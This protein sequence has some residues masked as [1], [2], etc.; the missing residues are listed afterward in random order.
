MAKKI[1][2]TIK[3]IIGWLLL[4]LFVM[5]LAAGVFVYLKAPAYV[6]EN[7]SE[8]VNKKSNGVYNLQFDNIGLS[9]RKWG[10]TV[11]NIKLQP[12]DSLIHL[13]DPTQTKKIY[14]SFSSSEINIRNIGLIKLLF[15][16]ELKI[17]KV[18]ILKPELEVSGTSPGESVPSKNIE[19]LLQEFQPLLRKKLRSVTIK[20][21]ELRIIFAGA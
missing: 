8:W 16:K 9:I 3:K 21:I 17:G 13:S 11:E 2:H 15:L 19:L 18:E 1:I 14:Y 7:L 6:N 10:F 4:C 20:N 12:V 5:F